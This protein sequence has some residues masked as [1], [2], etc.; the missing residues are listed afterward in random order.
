[1]IAGL[2]HGFVDVGQP[3]NIVLLF[4]G[5][6]LG[7]IVGGLPGLSSPMAIVVLLPITYSMNTLSAMMILIGIYMGTKLG[8][9]FTAILMRIPGTPAGACTMLDGYPMMQKGQGSAALGYSTIA[10]VVGGV[11]G[12]IFAV[13]FVPVIAYVAQQTSNADIALIGLAGLIIVASMMPGSTLKGW[14]GALLGLLFGTV[15]LD[16]ISGVNRFTFGSINLMSGI[17]FLPALIGFFGFTVILKDIKSL[18][19]RGENVFGDA[20]ISLPGLSEVVK[21]WSSLAIGV[22]YGIAIGAVPG[23]GATTSTWIA[24]GFAKKRSKT[25]QLYGTGIPEGVLVP[26][27]AAAAGIGGALIPMLTLGIPGDGSTAILL[28]A[29]ILHN[30]QPGV[31]LMQNNPGIVYGILTAVL[32]SVVFMFIIARLMIRWFV[33]VFSQDRAWIFPIIIVLATVGAFANTNTIFPVYLAIGF[34]V[35]GYILES[36]GYPVI[37]IVLGLILGPIIEQNFR[38]ALALSNYNWLTFIAGWPERIMVLVIVVLIVNELRSAMGILNRP[39][40]A[41]E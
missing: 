5:T 6:G 30:V 21:R 31:M 12:W 3:L 23:V 15:G 36:R 17:P 11:I 4:L 19:V 10:A 8:G 37:T 34:G 28:G 16:P 38:I 1:M 40:A 32:I 18:D 39:A 14:I 35:L 25:P 24:Y 22:I 27:A 41:R 2:L 26:E 13:V 33:R 7:L 20:T 29:L 9:S